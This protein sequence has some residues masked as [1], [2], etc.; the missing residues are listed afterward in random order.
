[1]FF[2]TA[3]DHVF[4]DPFWD[5]PV[6]RSYIGV[7]YTATFRIWFQWDCPLV[8]NHHP[9]YPSAWNLNVL[10]VKCL[11]YFIPFWWELLTLIIMVLICL[12]VSFNV[13]TT[14][15]SDDGEHFGDLIISIPDSC[16]S[17][18]FPQKIENKHKVFLF[19]LIRP[20]HKAEVSLL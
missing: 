9:A 6:I 12:L 16:W 19:Y 7:I 8:S 10:C 18:N 1:M 3:I 2:G 11:R 13:F 5:D 4:S 15:L 14:F 20:A 17:N